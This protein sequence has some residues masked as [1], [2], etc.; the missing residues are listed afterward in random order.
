MALSSMLTQPAPV[1]GS[2]G[3]KVRSHHRLYLLD[4]TLVFHP[5]FASSKRSGKGNKSAQIYHFLYSRDSG[6][7][8]RSSDRDNVILGRSGL[9]LPRGTPYSGTDATVGEDELSAMLAKWEGWGLYFMRESEQQ[10]SWTAAIFSARQV[11]SS[12]HWLFGCV[13]PRWMMAT[14]EAALEELQA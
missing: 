2:T 5:G 8:H 13:L 3:N 10:G 9:S 14:G 7:Y 6:Q 12:R 4:S 11:S 1:W